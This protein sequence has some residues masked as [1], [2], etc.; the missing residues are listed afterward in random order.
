ME[1]RLAGT[2]FTRW[3]HLQMFEEGASTLEPNQGSSERKSNSVCIV[4]SH[5]VQRFAF[6]RGVP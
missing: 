3:Q 2:K 6:A 5:D 4:Q 1:G